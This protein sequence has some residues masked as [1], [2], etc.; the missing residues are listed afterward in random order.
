MTPEE[1]YQEALSDRSAAF[2]NME[3]YHTI[4][5]GDYKLVKHLRTGDVNL[6]KRRGEYYQ[7]CYIEKL[8]EKG[9]KK[10]IEELNLNSNE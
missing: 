1:V 8:L 4:I 10:G 9:W 2:I 3:S 7:F 6:M 5:K